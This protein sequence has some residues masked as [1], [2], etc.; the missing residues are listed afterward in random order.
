LFTLPYVGDWRVVPVCFD[1]ATLF[2]AFFKIFGDFRTKPNFDEI[3]YVKTITMEDNSPDESDLTAT[4]TFDLHHWIFQVS[5]EDIWL[6]EILKYLEM[7]D[8]FR[9]RG[10]CKAS[11]E[12]VN[13]HFSRLKRLDLTERRNFN[14]EQY[15]VRLNSCTKYY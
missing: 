13:I 9:F 4:T 7:E 15:E 12:L 8:L 2:L 11:Y 14:L 3:F 1:Y 10:V 6:A 5:W